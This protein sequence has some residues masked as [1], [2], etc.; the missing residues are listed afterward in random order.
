MVT[1]LYLVDVND[2]N[3]EIPEEKIEERQ[4]EKFL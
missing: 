2:I 1:K 3:F 4:E